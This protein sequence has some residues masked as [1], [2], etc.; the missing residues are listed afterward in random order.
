MLKVIRSDQSVASVADYKI[1]LVILY[2]QDAATVKVQSIWQRAEE[3]AS[4]PQEGRMLDMSGA[5][6]I[7]YAG[8]LGGYLIYQTT[9]TRLEIIDFIKDDDMPEI[10]K[11]FGNQPGTYQ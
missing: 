2:R 8:C 5:T 11:L 3:L 7:S 9:Q 6:N 1:E 10:F 4:N